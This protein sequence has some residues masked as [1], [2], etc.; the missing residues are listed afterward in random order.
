[1]KILVLVAIAPLTL[2]LMNS[3]F[4]EQDKRNQQHK[5]RIHE[6]MLAALESLI[7]IRLSS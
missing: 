6:E 2:V 4:F 1:M 7:L 5:N 3:F